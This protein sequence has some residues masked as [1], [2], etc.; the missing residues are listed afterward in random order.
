MFADNLI[1]YR[2]GRLSRTSL[3]SPPTA[4]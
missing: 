4:E 3:N 1:R 2:V